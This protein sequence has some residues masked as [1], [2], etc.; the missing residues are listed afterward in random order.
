[1]DGSMH[2]KFKRSNSN[3][4]IT[5]KDR[6][7]STTATHLGAEHSQEKRGAFEAKNLWH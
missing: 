2:V 1:M 3:M 5:I 6:R 4:M 7:G